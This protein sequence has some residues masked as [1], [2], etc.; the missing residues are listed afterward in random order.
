MNSNPQA[1]RFCNE[2]VR[3]L[4]NDLAQLYYRSKRFLDQWNGQGMSALIN[5]DAGETMDDNA[6]EDGRPIASG[7]S[8]HNM[9]NRAAGIVVDFEASGSAKLNT[10]LAIANLTGE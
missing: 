3:P 7:N 2:K 1:V 6:T 10:I 4:A 8:C 9:Y 5:N